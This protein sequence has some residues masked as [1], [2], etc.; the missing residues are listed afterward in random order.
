M[1]LAEARQMPW[2]TRTRIL[3]N[4]RCTECRPVGPNIAHTGAVVALGAGALIWTL[5]QGAQKLNNMTEYDA[6]TG[7][8]GSAAPPR[9]DAVLVFGSTGKLGRQ[10]VLQVDSMPPHV[11]GVFVP[12]RPFLDQ[13]CREPVKAA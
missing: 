7:S 6:Q 10:V 13:S 8:S 4:W 11:P 2:H 9:K 5:S 12:M 3:R 1:L